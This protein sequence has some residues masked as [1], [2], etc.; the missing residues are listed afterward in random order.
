MGGAYRRGTQTSSGSPQNQTLS[1]MAEKYLTLQDAHQEACTQRDRAEGVLVALIKGLLP[2]E[3]PIYLHSAG[4]RELDRWQLNQTMARYGLQVRSRTTYS[5]RVVKT[6][7]DQDRWAGHT[8]FWLMPVAVAGVVDE[9]EAA[10]DQ[11]ETHAG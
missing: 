10:S 11:A 5:E 9:T 3:R 8:Q 7:L 6:R 1:E 4:V 2:G